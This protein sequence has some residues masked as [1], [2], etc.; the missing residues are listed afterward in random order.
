MAGA[1]IPATC[2]SRRVL[3]RERGFSRAQGVFQGCFVVAEVG[4][5]GG[6]EFVV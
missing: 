4:G 5:Y 1:I 3:C 2:E 6:D